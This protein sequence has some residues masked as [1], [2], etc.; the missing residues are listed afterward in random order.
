MPPITTAV[1]PRPPI[2]K[3]EL[4]TIKGLLFDGN[5]V[6]INALTSDTSSQPIKKFFYKGNPRPIVFLESVGVNPKSE[7]AYLKDQI[8]LAK[9]LQ[10]KV[11]SEVS[12]LGCCTLQWHTRKIKKYVD[13]SKSISIKIKSL[14]DNINSQFE[15]EDLNSEIDTL[16]DYLEN[17]AQLNTKPQRKNIFEILDK[18]H[19][20]LKSIESC[21]S[22]EN[23][24]IFDK[25]LSMTEREKFDSL[26]DDEAIKYA[27][28]TGNTWQKAIQKNQQI[29]IFRWPN[30]FDSNNEEIRSS[31][32]YCTYLKQNEA[33]SKQ[34]NI[35]KNMLF[36]SLEIR[37]SFLSQVKEKYRENKNNCKTNFD[38]TVKEYLEKAD[39]KENWKNEVG[40]SDEEIKIACLE[41]LF[42]E[43]AWFAYMAKSH[44]DF[45]IAYEGE[46]TPAIKWIYENFHPEG[47]ICWITIISTSHKSEEIVTMKD[48]EIIQHKTDGRY[49][50]LTIN[51][52]GGRSVSVT[53]DP[54]IIPIS[55]MEETLAAGLRVAKQNELIKAASSP[56]PRKAK[57]CVIL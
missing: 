5:T 38:R 2:Q 27:L 55:K 50:I 32:D 8:L 41:Y 29:P 44:P 23:K 17:V 42:E 52:E 47:E 4:P 18:L 43:C 6:P 25:L 45:L 37:D 33:K 11:A 40:F 36:P 19:D 1:L 20:N 15:N 9:I 7:G 48:N 56:E 34:S 51:L 16:I 30:I 13:L 10:S 21:I 3:N 28:R 57:P 46:P 31:P 53:A 49:E 12:I 22:S 26:I 14:W 39:P 35:F 54:N 24:E